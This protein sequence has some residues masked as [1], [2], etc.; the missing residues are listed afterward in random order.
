MVKATVYTYLLGT[1]YYTYLY[2]SISSIGAIATSILVWIMKCGTDVD[3]GAAPGFPKSC[4]DPKWIAYLDPL[5]TL[6][7]VGWLSFV[8]LRIILKI[9]RPGQG[10]NNEQTN[11]V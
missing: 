9:F 7:L 10:T 3:L 6:V 2:E 1:S 4:I 8:N 5:F 11:S